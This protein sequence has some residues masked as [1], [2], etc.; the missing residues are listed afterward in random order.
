MAAVFAALGLI[1]A[2]VLMPANSQEPS[3]NETE[4][5]AGM[6]NQIPAPA[7]CVRLTY[8]EG[9]FMSWLGSLGLKKNGSIRIFDGSTVRSGA[10]HVWAVV[11]MPLL[12]QDDLEQCADYCMR[13]WAEYN[14]ASFGE[15]GEFFLYDYNG[16]KKYFRNSG[17]SF[18]KFLRNSMSCS[19]SF[20]ILKGG[21]PVSDA[22]A[23][24]GDMFVQNETGGIGHVSMI[25]DAC[26]EESG[27]IYFLVGFSFMPAQEFHI[28]KAP[29]E[30][31]RD[32]WFDLEGYRNYLAAFYNY[33]TPHLR[34]F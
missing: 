5:T 29:P 27:R 19:N 28:E 4:L 18:V 1:L 30:Y 16:R 23:R 8:S 12:F 2:V 7:S 15:Q 6:V 22:D 13:F 24:P 14:K 17:L 11:D 34:R 25:M 3:Q 32:G 33:G 9:S 21:I 20:S 10:Y 26:R 31:G